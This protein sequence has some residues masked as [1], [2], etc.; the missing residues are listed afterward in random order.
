MS[1]FAYSFLIT[2]IC[3]VSFQN[4]R[5]ACRSIAPGFSTGAYYFAAALALGIDI[6]IAVVG[7]LLGK[8][9]S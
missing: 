3:A 5:S 8:A 6:L 7:G 1:P 2:L 9:L 4:Y